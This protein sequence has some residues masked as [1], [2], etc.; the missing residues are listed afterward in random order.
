MAFSPINNYQPHPH[1]ELNT[2]LQRRKA[3]LQEKVQNLRS[4]E[5]QTVLQGMQFEFNKERTNCKFYTTIEQ[6]KLQNVKLGEEFEETV[7]MFSSSNPS[8]TQLEPLF[9]GVQVHLISGGIREDLATQVVNDALE[10]LI[11]I[12]PEKLPII[13]ER[14]L[15]SFE[16]MICRLEDGESITKYLYEEQEL[17]LRIKPLMLQF[18][19]QLANYRNIMGVEEQP[20]ERITN[21]FNR[22]VNTSSRNYQLY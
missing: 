16:S 19:D 21:I 4:F 22:T 14:S 7:K 12:P 3:H 15:K 11:A 8:K 5:G 18:W 20:K 17:R 13:I 2:I 9:D 1:Q 10:F 6:V